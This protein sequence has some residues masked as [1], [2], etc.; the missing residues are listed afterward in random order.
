MYSLNVVGIGVGVAVGVPIGV[1]VGVVVSS[2]INAQ[3]TKL[4]NIKELINEKIIFFLIFNIRLNLF[5]NYTSRIND[6]KYIK[7][8][9]IYRNVNKLG[10]NKIF[11]ELYTIN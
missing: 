11:R 6:E 5:G 1:G 2:S 4:K 3:E 8:A 7:N 10:I 9:L